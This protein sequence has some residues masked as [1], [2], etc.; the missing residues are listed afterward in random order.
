M[1]AI[2]W[3]AS[4]WR[5]CYTW[6]A[7]NVVSEQFNVVSHGDTL[8]G[9]A[10]WV[11]LV[12]VWSEKSHLLPLPRKP[13]F[14]LTLGRQ[15]LFVLQNKSTFEELYPRTTSTVP[16]HSSIPSQYSQTLVSNGVCASYHHS[17]LCQRL[18]PSVSCSY[19]FTCWWRKCTR[20]FALLCRHSDWMRSPAARLEA[21]SLPRTWHSISSTTM[22]CWRLVQMSLR[23]F[24]RFQILSSNTIT[25]VGVRTNR[26][27]AIRMQG[28]VF[29]IIYTHMSR[30]EISFRSIESC[31]HINIL[32]LMLYQ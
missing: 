17:W 27:S 25:E 18:E 11:R 9:Q 4:F 31:V 30:S 12:A 14:Y 3:S 10:L 2:R 22:T 28:K 16:I 6:G 15:N 23:L 24:S 5:S 20:Y 32:F 1:N 21:G 19:V 13:F 26:S 29:F 7:T 8:F